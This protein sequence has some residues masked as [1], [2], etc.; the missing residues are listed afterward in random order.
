[1]T[2]NV[3]LVED[4][5]LGVNWNSRKAQHQTITLEQSEHSG[6]RGFVS[7]LDEALS[8]NLTSKSPL[9]RNLDSRV[10][11]SFV[12]DTVFMWTG[13]VVG[14]GSSDLQYLRFIEKLVVEAEHFLIFRV[15]GNAGWR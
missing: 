9:N 10:L 7:P 8:I 13:L 12:M 5:F 6:E 1:M 15:G 2:A 4:S 3:V 14:V 11:P